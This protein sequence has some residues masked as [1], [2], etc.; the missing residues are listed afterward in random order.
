VAMMA[1]KRLYDNIASLAGRK[2]NGGKVGKL[3][4]KGKG[5]Y[6]SLAY[7]QSGFV[8]NAGQGTI[9]LS[10]VG[11][12]RAR[13]HRPLPLNCIIKGVVI[14]RAGPWKWFACLQC[15]DPRASSGEGD[16]GKAPR[17]NAPFTGSGRAVGIDLG[18]TH[19][20]ADSDG[21]FAASPRYLEKSLEKVRKLQQHLSRRKP[22]SKRRQKA[23]NALAK[24]H[25]KVAD[26]R[27]DFL[28]K[29]SRHYV[30]H[31]D[32][33]CAEDLDVAGMLQEK[34]AALS[35]TAR[36]TLRRH[37]ADAGWRSFLNMVAYKA[38]SAGKRAVFVNPRGTSQECAA[39][40]ATV[41]K[42]LWDRVH[43]C[44]HC[45]FT[46]DRDINASLVI[47]KRGTGQAPT[48]V[49]LAPLLRLAGA[50]AGAEAGILASSHY[51]T[52]Q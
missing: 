23:R 34:R 52:F 4:F 45:G 12:V 46:T 25:E 42:Q 41:P 5:S 14:K 39:C 50:S 49:E 21:H 43:N 19:F 8:V 13:F 40:G 47:L 6:N 27:R 10:K 35:P 11:V 18:I 28:H 7:N 51:I 17:K 15:D 3:R 32:V 20:T 26:Q 44:P 33:I 31:Y 38:L 37:T 2:R 22:A 30:D 1:A 24:L 16:P 9:Y 48:S 36:R 29:L